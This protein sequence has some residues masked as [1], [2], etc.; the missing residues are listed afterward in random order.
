M[1]EIGREAIGTGRTRA[2]TVERAAVSVADL[3]VRYNAR[4]ALRGVSACFG[5]GAVHALVGPS[6]C[7]KTTL[8]SCL[9]RLTD[10]VPGCRVEGSALLDGV[11]TRDI[12]PVELRRRVGMIFQEPNPFPLSIRRNVELALREH[13][14]RSRAELE[15]RVERA[16]FDAGLFEEVKD[17]LGESA[18]SLSG[19]QQQRLCI[20]R[21]I[22][23]EPEVLLMDEPTS[24][25]DPIAA[26][27]IERWIA[28]A[29]G[30][31]TILFVTHNLAQARRLAD[32][33][34]VF[35]VSNDAGT[36]VEQ[37]P[38]EQIFERPQSAITT[39]YVR[40]RAG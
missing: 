9:N 30:R 33:I 38:T 3:A 5:A 11:E 34:A 27:V 10:L 36:I 19:G 40:G 26:E 21:A 13:G 6:G 2:E 31:Y 18:L 35:W 37:G 16:L 24:S 17:R 39:A 15:Q 4:W 23:L 1:T 20:A 25:L 14:V 12:H 29:R 28:R 8:L 7:G 22:A 32:Q